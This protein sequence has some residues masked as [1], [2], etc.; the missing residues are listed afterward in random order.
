MNEVTA[1]IQ[2]LAA[3]ESLANDIDTLAVL[4]RQL[5]DLESKVK[6]LKDK[7]ANTYGEGTH[8]GEM[9]GVRVGLEQRKGTVDY[10]KVCK[11]FGISDEQLESFRGESIAVI[12]VASIA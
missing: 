6:A 10:K 11:A 9:Y 8:R 12:K 3:V 4:D 7:V 5:K 1:T 2:A